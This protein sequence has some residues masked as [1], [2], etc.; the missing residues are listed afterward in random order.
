MLTHIS[1]GGQA[2]AAGPAAQLLSQL[3][4]LIASTRRAE[5]FL[6]EASAVIPRDGG[7]DWFGGASEAF[8]R[9]CEAHRAKVEAA[10]SD[11][12]AARS[13]MIAAIR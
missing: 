3:E 13:L 5:A 8:F 6:S 1:S 11:F 9:E 4:D 12:G 7:L 10:A 2:I